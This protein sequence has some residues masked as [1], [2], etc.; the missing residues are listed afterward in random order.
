M[1]LIDHLLESKV[2]HWDPTIRELSGSALASLVEVAPD[3]I[4]ETALPKL[5]VMAT[6]KDMESR[7][8]AIIAVG[9]I[10]LALANYWNRGLRKL[11][12]KENS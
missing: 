5:V 7:H 3:Y 4:V 2:N 1:I 8:G 9:E 10:I 12:S 11:C 6:D